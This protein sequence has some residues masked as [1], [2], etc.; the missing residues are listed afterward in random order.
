[1]KAWSKLLTHTTVSFLFCWE[2]Y[3]SSAPSPQRIL[4]PHPRKS[5][6]PTDSSSTTTASIFSLPVLTSGIYTKK[7]FESVNNIMNQ[8]SQCLLYQKILMEFCSI[9]H[10][11]LMWKGLDDDDID[12]RN[13]KNTLHRAEQV[14]FACWT[15]W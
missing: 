11:T 12:V 13:L 2:R 10:P 3:P 4:A 1:M 6:D 7:N 15:W 8:S 14:D 9:A 5:K